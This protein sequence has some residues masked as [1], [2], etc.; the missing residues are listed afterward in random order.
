MPLPP[1]YL[2][3]SL[4][5]PYQENNTW[6]PP[7]P[8]T[9][10]KTESPYQDPDCIFLDNIVHELLALIDSRPSSEKKGFD[11]LPRLASATNDMLYAVEALDCLCILILN[12]RCHG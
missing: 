7:Q 9:N 6:Q 2:E 8:D 1:P 11:P 10:A 5:I 3:T 4:L 12:V